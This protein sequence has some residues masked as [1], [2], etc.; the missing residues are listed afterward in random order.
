MKSE[1]RNSKSER[2]PKSEGR[3]IRLGD[4]S[5]RISDFGLLSG[6]GFR[7]SDFG[8]R[9]ESAFDLHMRLVRKH[10]RPLL[11]LPCQRR[12]AAACLGLYPAPT[13]RARIGRDR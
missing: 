12:A 1:I 10:G 4:A 11:L 7:V 6:F 3:N 5:V 2:R 9:C 8:Q 13:L